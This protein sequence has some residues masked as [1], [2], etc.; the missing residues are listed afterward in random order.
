[1]S[2]KEGGDSKIC[3][4]SGLSGTNAAQKE[5]KTWKKKVLCFDQGLLTQMKEEE[6]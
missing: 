2:L 3:D 4:G 6:D 5:L 1:M